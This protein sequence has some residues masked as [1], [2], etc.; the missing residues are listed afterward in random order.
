MRL[1]LGRKDKAKR[2]QRFIDVYP[3]MEKRADAQI[4]AIDLRYDTGLAVSYKPVQEQQL[5]NKSKA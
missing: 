2:V 3:R 1:N 5:Q 4:D